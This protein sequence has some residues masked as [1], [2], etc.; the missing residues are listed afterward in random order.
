[1]KVVKFVSVVV[2]LVS[3]ISC[4]TPEEKMKKYLT[5][6]WETVF[7]KIE[8]PTYQ[9]KDTLLEYD[10]D[11]TNPEDP[12]AKGM[13][14]SFT[15]HN[16][17]GTFETWQEKNGTSAGGITK[18][19]WKT[20]LDSL[21]YVIGEGKKSFTVSFAVAKIEDGFSLRGIQDRDRDGEQDDIFYLETVRRPYPE[22]K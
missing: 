18:G 7:L 9:R 13:P 12:R 17:D 10:V 20:T 19:N 4:S 3:I 1:M 16:L 15:I 21:Y 5:G 8:M 6:K 2:L 14:V 22:E 11:F